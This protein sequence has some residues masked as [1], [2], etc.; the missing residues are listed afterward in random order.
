MKGL[1]LLTRILVSN[2]SFT[3]SRRNLL[4]PC[5]SSVNLTLVGARDELRNIVGSPRVWGDSPQNDPS[6]ANAALPTKQ[7]DLPA[8]H[9]LDS[10]REGVIPLTK[11]KLLWQKY[12]NFHR[13]IRFGRIME[14]LDTMAV[15]VSYSHNKDPAKGPDQKSSIVI[16]TALVDS[17]KIKAKAIREDRDVII[18]GHTTWV[19]TTSMEI[20]LSVD[21]ENNGSMDPIM[22]AKFLMV[23]RDPG[24]K[25]KAVVNPLAVETP[26]ERALFEAG[27]GSKLIRQTEAEFSLLKS[28]PS[29]DERLTIHDLFIKTLDIKSATFKR[30]AKPENSMWMDEAVLK[31]VI[32]CFPEKRNLYSKIFGG[33][34]MRQA[35]ELAWTNSCLF[36]KTRPRLIGVD[37]IVFRRPVELGSLLFLSSQV[38]YTKGSDLQVKVHAEVVDPATGS[39]E[40]T[41]I[42]HYTFTTDNVEIPT[43]IPRSYAEYMLYLDGKRRFE[44]E[45]GKP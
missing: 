19:G 9:M 42:F 3:V 31:N 30:F 15:L 39:H 34:L 21:Q 8:R 23:A 13:R 17:I 14:D 2:T 36:S 7:S 1:K 45:A 16:V 24:N 32:I 26:E 18:R 38:V 33:F 6:S 29:V 25:V 28:P 10:Y 41:N 11:D 27:E 20:S 5:S 44:K 35:F 40:T 22:T 4:I 43:I 37:D 12:V